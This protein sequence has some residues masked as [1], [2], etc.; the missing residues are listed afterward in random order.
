M[1]CG[2]CTGSY[3]TKSAK[4]RG[5]AS[6]TGGRCYA[7]FGKN[8]WCY[9][10]ARDGTFK[11]SNCG[12][13]NGLGTNLC[14]PNLYKCKPA[15]APLPAPPP[16]ALA[17]IGGGGG[18]RASKLG[19]F[20]ANFAKSKTGTKVYSKMQRTAT[21]FDLALAAIEHAESAGLNPLFYQKATGWKDAYAW[22]TKVVP[23]TSAQ[24]GD[25]AQFKGWKEGYKIAWNPHTAVVTD[26]YKNGVLETHEQNPNPV[27]KGDYHPGQQSS[28][29]VTIYRLLTKSRL[30]LYEEQNSE[31]VVPSIF[32]HAG[33]L[34]AVAGGA[35]ATGLLSM[36]LLAVKRYRSRQRYA[37]ANEGSD[38]DPLSADVE[39]LE[40]TSC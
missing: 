16:G 23:V 10:Q 15:A 26:C 38:A 40:T 1:P 29:E 27:Q 9:T 21:C 32:S 36:V 20:V 31:A 37:S 30:R 25:I 35:A 14:C 6:G 4:L 11:N 8:K 12:S 22:S 18:C 33:I 39:L 7:Y 2:K 5:G 13:Y 24:P 17:P 3:L 19:R 28:G 34:S